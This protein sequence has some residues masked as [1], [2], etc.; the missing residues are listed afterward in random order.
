MG[1]V[2][3]VHDLVEHLFRHQA[4]QMLATLSHTLG[5]ENLD[6][7]EEAVQEALLQALRLW[8]FHG[9]PDNPRTWLIHVAR[10]KVLDR[11]RRRT[12]L[13]RKERELERLLEER[14]S[15]QGGADPAEPGEL[16][17]EQLAMIF[18]CCDPALPQEARVALT[19]KAVGGFSVPEIARAFLAEEPTI[20]QRLVR[21]KRRIKDAKITL[22][23][24]PPA[25]LPGRLDSVLQVLYLLYS[26]GYGAHAGEDLVREDLCGEAMRLAGL[27]A[28]HPST[29][30]PKVHALL[31]LFYLQAARLST[32]VDGDGNLLLLAEQDR[33]E[34]D[35]GLLGYGL[36]HLELAASG[37][38]L[39]EYHLQAGIAAVHATSPSFDDTDWPYLLGLY[40]E[41]LARARSPVVALNRAIA[42]SM[43]EGPEAALRSLEGLSTDPA[44][45]G[46]YLLPAVR[47][48]LLRRL[49]RADEAA[50][51]YRRA[52]DLTCTEP[53]RN[54]LSR[55][56]D[57]LVQG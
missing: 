12:S 27:L 41:L 4:G 18:A 33:A 32:R 19:L 26:E 20:A 1:E 31:A 45:K 53:E 46:Y 40:D 38:E 11:L 47:A 7:A 56:L 13:R 37:D 48:D 23:L 5:L 6:L 10:N 21:A 50:D 17:D 39:S 35:R 8:P 29:S 36:R 30:L 14:Q 57:G 54:F 28:A 9:V 22:A 51:C 16:E 52:L 25:E 55:R 43:I 42:L 34:W 3:R 15:A 24:P 2:P 49:G 44:M